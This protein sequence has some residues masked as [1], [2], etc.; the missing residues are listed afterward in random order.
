MG[1]AASEADGSDVDGDGRRAAGDS[2][3]AILEFAL[4]AILLFTLVFGIIHYGLLLSFKQDMTRAAAEGARAAA[5]ALP[6]TTE[7]ASDSRRLAAVDATNEAVSELNRT[8]NSG[9][10]MTCIVQ[11]HDCDVAPGWDD[12]REIPDSNGYAGN[13]EPDCV[14]VRLEYDRAGHPL[15]APLPMIEPFL[16]DTLRASSV[17][18]LNE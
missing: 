4:V 14:T 3:A 15:L 2:G 11:I 17:V 8:C 10:G 13:D 18:R 9:D 16:P 12:R 1:E 6:S 5:V 7:G